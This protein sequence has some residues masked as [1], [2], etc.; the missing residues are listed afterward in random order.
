M[1]NRSG[2][3][4]ALLL[5]LNAAALAAQTPAEVQ[6]ARELAEQAGAAYRVNDLE[7]SLGLLEKALRLRPAHSVMLYNAARIAARMGS[8]D[9][10]LEYLS[11]AAQLGLVID[12]KGDTVLSRLARDARFTPIG[13]QLARNRMPVGSSDV[14]FRIDARAFLPEGIAFDRVTRS[15]L[16][17]S[18]HQRR[19]VRIDSAGI[20]RDF[21][22]AAAG[23][24]SP[25]ALAARASSPPGQSRLFG[26]FGIAVDAARRRVWVTTAA[27]SQVRDVTSAELGHTA[28]HVYDADTGELERSYAPID[29]AAHRF[30]DVAVDTVSGDAYVSDDDAGAVYRIRNG[31]GE[32]SALVTSGSLDSPQ[33]MAV[34][35]AE[36]RLIVADYSTGLWQ[37]DMRTGGIVQLHGER[38]LHLIGLD[39]LARHGGDVIVIQNYPEPHR[40]LRIAL[41]PELDRITGYEV[42]ESMN[43]AFSEPT[44]GV[45]VGDAFYYIANSQWPLFAPG[46][47]ADRASAEPPIILRARLR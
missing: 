23:A 43:E 24:S 32:L 10:A 11:A 47:E 38:P 21:V 28:V 36:Q 34:F 39:G 16:V 12:L 15:F 18:V 3:T 5:A 4:C 41:S 26:V 6:R 9:R 7:K 29:S 30:G 33:G 31:S 1:V 42:I 14:A 20:A 46:R 22:A 8:T 40:V 44:L 13:E 27:L 45:V 35:P 25:P 17:G 19:I 2:T 37:V